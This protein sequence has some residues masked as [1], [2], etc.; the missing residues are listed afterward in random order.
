[1]KKWTQ[2]EKEEEEEGEG[3]GR[4][5]IRSRRKTNMLINNVSGFKNI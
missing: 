4:K 3:K 2:E 5:T 1:M